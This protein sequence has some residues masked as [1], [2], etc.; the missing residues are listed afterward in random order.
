LILRPASD[1]SQFMQPVIGN[2]FLTPVLKPL[3]ECNY[4][5][6]RFSLIP[7][8]FSTKAPLC[9]GLSFHFSFSPIPQ[10][11]QH[12]RPSAQSKS[13]SS[14]QCKNANIEFVSAFMKVSQGL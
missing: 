12:H 6:T 5:V 3:E 1:N 9:S 14:L 4:D 11:L 10:L 7:Q 2:S 13:S 8:Q